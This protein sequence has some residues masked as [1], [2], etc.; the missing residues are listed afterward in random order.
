M[1]HI[2]KCLHEV[3]LVTFLI[4]V[5]F[6]SHAQQSSDIRLNDIQI[7]GTHNSYH[8][9]IPPNEMLYERETHPRFAESIDYQHLPLTAQLDAGVRQLE[10]DVY[11]DS[12]GGLFDNP[13]GPHNATKYGLSPDPPF[14]PEDV[15]KKPGFKVL[16]IQDIDYRSNC[17]PFMSCLSII[18]KWSLTHPRHL[19]IF[20]LIENKDETGPAFMVKPEPVTDKTFDDLD[21]VIRSVFVPSEIVIPDDVRGKHKT[22][23]EAIVSSGWPLLDSARGK[24]IFLLDQRR[25]EQMYVRDHPSLEGRV[26][27]ANSAPGSPDAAFIEVND[28]LADPNLI[29]SLVRKGYLVRTMTDPEPAGIRAGDT[30]RRDAAMASGAQILST[31]YPCNERAKSGYCVHFIK[32]IVRC[33]P[34]LNAVSCKPSKVLEDVRP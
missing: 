22:L 10:L 26:M 14:D 9:S 11:G 31:D 8:V 12:K 29:P 28:P 6:T 30:R 18:R 23:E 24:V 19:P 3:F 20:V 32:R 25:F 27:F 7:I 15:M 21:A 33:D 34:I 1:R 5:P 2:M 16:H 13:A 4:C 17:Q